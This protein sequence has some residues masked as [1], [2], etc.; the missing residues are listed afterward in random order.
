MK[1]IEREIEQYFL[2]RPGETVTLGDLLD[3]IPS[4]TLMQIIYACE[5]LEKIGRI[6]PAEEVA[7]VGLKLRRDDED[8]FLQRGIETMPA[9][10]HQIERF[11]E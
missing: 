7:F 10:M 1:F 2:D 4:V 9:F 5:H 11:L 8:E 6:E 3:A